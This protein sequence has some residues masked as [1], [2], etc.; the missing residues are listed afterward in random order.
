MYTRS[1]A[2]QLYP[3]LHQENCGQQV[4]GGDAAPLLYSGVTPPGV[5]IPALEPPAQQGLGAVRADPEEGHKD[6]LRAGKPLL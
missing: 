3:G 4:K 6:D 5:L 1:P 2:G